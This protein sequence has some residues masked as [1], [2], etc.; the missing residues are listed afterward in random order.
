MLL[1][2]SLAKRK[3]GQ[4]SPRE[5]KR[6][7]FPNQHGLKGKHYGEILEVEMKQGKIILTPYR[8]AS[9]MN[10]NLIMPACSIG[11]RPFSLLSRSQAQILPLPIPL[12]V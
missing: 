4:K 12:P 6:K 2:N 11:K 1:R 9:Q 3:E 8:G 7:N 10:E 5:S